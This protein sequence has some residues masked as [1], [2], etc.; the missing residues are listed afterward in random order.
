MQQPAPGPVTPALP[1]APVTILRERP[2]FVTLYIEV[3][4]LKALDTK[5]AAGPPKSRTTAER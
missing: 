4:K 5:P 3:V 2:L 1:T